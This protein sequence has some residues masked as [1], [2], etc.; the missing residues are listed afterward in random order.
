MPC[1]YIFRTC[2]L[3]PSRATLN[4]GR[5]SA[6]STASAALIVLDERCAAAH[7]RETA[8][9]MLR[10]PHLAP[11]DRQAGPDVE[12]SPPSEIVLLLLPR[13]HFSRFH[14]RDTFR[15]PGPIR[16]CN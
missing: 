9:R 13:R 14:F 16:P 15:V 12:V 4:S 7:P 5:L 3:P 6:K 1:V 11:A 8:G 2:A 10:A